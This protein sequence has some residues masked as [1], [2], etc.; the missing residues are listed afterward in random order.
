M[1][2]LK[3]P[4]ILMDPSPL[5][6]GTIEAAHLEN[7]VGTIIPQPVTC[8]APQQPSLAMQVAIVFP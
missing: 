1:V 8:R 2:R 4:Q 3:S 7:L 5:T 6:T